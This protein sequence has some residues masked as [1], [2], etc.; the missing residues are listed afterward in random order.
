MPGPYSTVFGHAH[1]RCSFRE[2]R[3]VTIANVDDSNLYPWSCIELGCHIDK[4]THTLFDCAAHRL[5]HDI[6][7]TRH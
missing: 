5:Q 2:H 4:A 7:R 3:Y 6:D 1:T